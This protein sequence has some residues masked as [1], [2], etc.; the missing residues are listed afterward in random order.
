M[1][2]TGTDYRIEAA[3]YNSAPALVVYQGDSP[4]SVVTVEFIDG[5]I[6][7]FYAM[8][9]PE[10]LGA[11]TVPQGDQPLGT[12]REQS[13]KTPHARRVGVFCVCSAKG[14]G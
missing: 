7:N 4:D 14:S 5:Q 6:T 13:Q 8:R 1:R 9:N 10:K 2:R 11:V 12:S 3:V